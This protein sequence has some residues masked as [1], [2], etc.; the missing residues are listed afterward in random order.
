MSRRLV[1]MFSSLILAAGALWDA[2]R[3]TWLCD[4]A[5]ISFRYADH[6]ARGH[7]LVFNVGERVEGYTNFLW[8]VLLGLGSWAGLAPEA[9]SGLLSLA[10]F[11]GL[12]GL[13]YRT[14]IT[15][16]RDLGRPQPWLS[17]GLAGIALHEHHR[18]WATSGL[19]TTLFT[20]L[21][22]GTVIA[23][24]EARSDKHWLV[25]GALGALATL[26]RPEGALIYALAWA[27][28]AIGGGASARRGLAA[29]LP[30]VLLVG[31]WVVWK[32]TFYGDLLPNT[33]YAKDAGEGQWAEGAAY[34]GLYLT[35]YLALLPALG[36]LALWTLRRRAGSGVGWAGPRAPL[37]LA[38]VTCAWLLHV[39]RVGGDFMFARFLI[40][41][42]PLW[43][44]ALDRGIAA[45]PTRTGVSIAA[46]LLIGM[47]LSTPPSGLLEDAG[48]DGVVEERSW[49][50]EAWRNEAARQGGV[51]R[52]VL[53]DSD[54]R[55]VYYGTQ[56]MLMYYGDVA[57]ALEGH[58]GLTDRDLARSGTL[59]GTRIGHGKKATLEYLRERQI[60]LV[61]D[62]RMQLP[63]PPLTRIE[64]GEGVGGRLLIYRREV[65]R[66]LRARGARFVDF[67]AFL[68]EYVSNLD[69][70]P[71]SKVSREY[72]T[73]Q[74]YWFDHN[75][76][77]E[78][79]AAFE[80]RLNRQR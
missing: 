24:V 11:A 3:L 71:D 78:R 41:V 26:T 19:E 77:P 65:A 16:H 73:F 74:S 12:L 18:I 62:F 56:A 17:V 52:Q 37:L 49:Y 58:V 30:G 80:Q 51:L 67:E 60:D 36:A 61:L 40:P 39:C 31:P 9:L 6:F 33:F 13:L 4:D 32:L 14:S 69:A 28:A 44:V 47:G 20:L 5:F 27:S 22:T 7:G 55:I 54:A 15:L 25:V 38:A 75:E 35:T 53:A 10:A 76:D 66:E 63:T 68:D 70:M 29:A 21:V 57:Y 50:P 48:V 1:L 72:A 79:Q 34:V 59:P 46:A 64:L 23:A 43:L 42:T 2:S 45:L 8:T